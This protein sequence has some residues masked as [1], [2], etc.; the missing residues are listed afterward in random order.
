MARLNLKEAAQKRAASKVASKV[1]R[2]S[3]SKTDKSPATALVMPNTSTPTSNGNQFST[4]FSTT[5]TEVPGLPALSP[6]SVA[7]MLPQFNE[8]SYVISDPLNPPE[9]LPQ[10]SETQFNKAESTYQG[11][12]R[13]LKLSGMAFDVA[14]A[15][16]TVIGKRAKAFGSGIKAATAVERVKG[17]YLD[18]QSQLE[19]TNQKS[20]ALENNQAKTANDR[21]VSVHTQ[22][23]MDEKLKQAEADADMARQKT[24]E[25]QNQLAEFKKQLGEYLPSN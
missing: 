12:L 14:D 2:G 23:F 20:V 11:T 4:S 7:G 18:Y 19:T 9:S 25:K 15:R 16:F 8:E 1:A 22:A 5:S 17:D 13:A 3:K 21:A 6:D 24:A 10:I